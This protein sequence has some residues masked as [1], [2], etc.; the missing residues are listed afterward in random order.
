MPPA[1]SPSNTSS[2]HASSAIAPESATPSPT[3][4]RSPAYA[5]TSPAARR[6][7][8]ESIEAIPEGTDV[9]SLLIALHRLGGVARLE[10]DFET[11]A[12]L[13]L[14]SLRLAVQANDVANI[15][16]ALEGLAELATAQG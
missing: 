14:Q 13:E 15:S 12:N 10:G 11:A 16:Q 9:Y 6:L 3:S 4:G 1:T 7:L 8:T 2:A 5:A